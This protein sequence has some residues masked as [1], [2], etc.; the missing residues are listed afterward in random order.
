MQVPCRQIDQLQASALALKEGECQ[1][2]L[3]SLRGQLETHANALQSTAF[4]RARLVKEL[5]KCELEIQQSEEGKA[6]VTAE[7]HAV[8]DKLAKLGVGTRKIGSGAAPLPAAARRSGSGAASPP[9]A[10]AKPGPPR[11]TSAA[12][13][14]LLRG[15]SRGGPVL[16]TGGPS[17]FTGPQPC[18]VMLTEVNNANVPSER[19][20]FVTK[21]ATKKARVE[22][23]KQ[24]ATEKAEAEK[25]TA[26]K[27]EAFRLQ[28][29]DAKKGRRHAELS[30]RLQADTCTSP[31][32]RI[33]CAIR[34]C[35]A[36]RH[37]A[38]L[39]RQELQLHCRNLQLKSL[40]AVRLW[41]QLMGHVLRDVQGLSHL[42]R[43]TSSTLKKPPPIVVKAQKSRP[44]SLKTALQEGNWTLAR[45]SQHNIYKRKVVM[46]DGQCRIQTTG[47]AKTPSDF[48]SDR[49]QLAKLRGKL[50]YGVEQSY[51]LSCANEECST[52]HSKV[53]QRPLEPLIPAAAMLSY[54]TVSPEVLI[55]NAPFLAFQKS[56]VA[57]CRTFTQR[58]HALYFLKGELATLQKLEASPATFEAP[59]PEEQR[60]RM[61]LV[62]GR[63]DEKYTWL[64]QEMER[65]M[66][67]GELTAGEQ[68]RMETK[69]QAKL[70]HEEAKQIGVSGSSLAAEKLRVK[71]RAV[72]EAEPIV[73][74][75]K[76]AANIQAH[77]TKL[78][79]LA[80]LESPKLPLPL[81]EVQKL[82][83]KPKLLEELAEMRQE[84]RGWFAGSEKCVSV[85]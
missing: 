76:L 73:W 35:N 17:E 85:Y 66:E 23:D 21:R 84:S 15:D 27:S 47:S 18:R 5:A 83:A 62:T 57:Y 44:N 3:H 24:A 77:E 49:N 20:P 72:R 31:A 74:P 69:M 10:A 46:A 60:D 54:D 4:R 9:V 53:G 42:L 32:I 82:S 50:D 75:V 80:E 6:R 34:C 58:Q 64:S 43:A 78:A 14:D 16:S 56:M 68:R 59:S 79:A 52:A 63:L 19:V 71:L 48:R 36:R 22:A 51:P 70:L 29:R 13:A 2:A 61:A 33:Q 39:H 81:S 25:Q 55:I 38:E 12:G 11:A 30:A 8:K 28:R 41:R 1:D 7:M 67:Q 65:M 26:A 45:D 40:K 37:C